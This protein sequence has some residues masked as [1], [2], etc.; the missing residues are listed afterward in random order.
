MFVGCS[1]AASVSRARNYV[2]TNRIKKCP[3]VVDTLLEYDCHIIP[4]NKSDETC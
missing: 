2:Q 3:T 4:T 1:L